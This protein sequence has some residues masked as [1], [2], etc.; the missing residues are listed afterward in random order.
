MDKEL[1]QFTKSDIFTPNEIS[2]LMST[3]IY[4]KGSLLE[5]SVGTGNLLKFLPIDNYEFIDVYELKKTYLDNFPFK[6]KNIKRFNL[7]FIKTTINKKYDNIIMNPPYIKVQDLSVDYRAY[8][9][10]KF[11]IL[12]N[13]L[14]DIY[15]A[16]ILK[17]LDLLNDDGVMVAITPNSYLYNKSAEKLRKYLFDNH[18]IQEIIDFKD[19]TVFNEASVYCCIT[20]FTKTKKN[21]LIYNDTV[22]SYFD[23]KKNYSLFNPMENSTNKI[24]DTLK[25]VCKIKNGIATLRDKIYIHNEKLFDEPCWKRITNGNLEKYIIYPYENGKIIEESTFKNDNP[26]TYEYLTKQKDELEKR[27]KGKKKYPAWYAFGRSQSIQF[28]NKK[29]IYIPCFINPSNIEKKIFVKEGMLHQSCLC[30]EPIN[31]NDIQ[32]IIKSII[33]NVEF[34]NNNSSKRS[35]G[36]ISLSSRVLYEIPFED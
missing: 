30:I 18:F 21:N 36:W 26:N 2:Q 32:K 3:K 23:I 20:I 28:S 17:C 13:G 6:N 5:P 29:C 1:Y 8:L 16:F 24:K 4:N 7:D 19:K 22:I 31:E 15:Y 10:E 34:I 33:K 27:D 12:K 35:G 14:V 9:K 25:S 11:P